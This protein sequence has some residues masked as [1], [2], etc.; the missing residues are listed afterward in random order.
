ML[1]HGNIDMTTP[2]HLLSG[3][4][5]Q[6][7]AIMMA[8]QKPTRVLLLDE[9]TA[10]LDNDNA[11]QVMAFLENITAELNLITLIICHDKELVVTY[12][13]HSC[14]E[15]VHHNGIRTFSP[16]LTTIK[17]RYA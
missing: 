15:L 17:E 10:A 13:H 14:Y 2:A 8:L 12:G 4:Q 5:R 11:Q 1:D 16:S 6:I 3:G 7:L 9:P